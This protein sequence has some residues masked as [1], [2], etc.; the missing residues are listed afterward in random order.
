MLIERQTK[1]VVTK[2]SDLLATLFIKLFDLRRIQCLPRTEDSYEDIEV[3]EVEAIVNK[4]LIAMVYKLN[5]AVFRPIFIRFSDWANGAALKLDEWSKLH[6]RVSWW[7]FQLQ[8]FGSMKSIVTSY[9]GLILDD[10]VEILTTTSLQDD[11]SRLLWQHVL[12][13][14]QSAFEHDQDDFFQTPSHFTPISTS[15]ISQLR[16]RAEDSSLSK[17]IAAIT[18]LAATTDSPAQHK[19]LCGPLLQLIRDESAAVRLA[20]VECQL[21]LTEKLGEE[22]LAQLPEMLAFI[23]EGMEDDDEG[24]EIE[25]R[26]WAKRIEDILGESIGAML[27]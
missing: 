24:V 26:K 9:A 7:T 2:Q 19:S 3:E 21:S 16:P 23:S 25:V 27:R 17:L 18:T 11:D 1:S 14:L 6:R 13:T 22:W 5:D 20:A 4:T 15:L 8:F 12:L 10:A